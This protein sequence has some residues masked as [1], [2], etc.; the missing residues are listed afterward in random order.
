M[1]I[2]E[3]S[4]KIN[5]SFLTV[6][7]LFFSLI[8]VGTAMIEFDAGGIGILSWIICLGGIVIACMDKII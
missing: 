5:P 1:S 4:N 8:A 3:N 2:F 6:A 7:W